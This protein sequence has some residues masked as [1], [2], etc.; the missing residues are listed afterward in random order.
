[1]ELKFK[2][3]VFGAKLTVYI[4]A[5]SEFKFLDQS[6]TTG[7]TTFIY[8]VETLDGVKKGN[9]YSIWISDGKNWLYLVH[10]CLHLVKNIFEYANIPF[11]A[12][13]HELIAYYQTYWVKTIWEEIHGV[14]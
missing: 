5:K 8:E 11:N 14:K 4:G 10:E 6:K 7:A 13:N 3:P 12:N 2:C 1:M 9:E